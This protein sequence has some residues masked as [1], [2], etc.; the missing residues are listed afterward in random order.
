MFHYSKWIEKNLSKIVYCEYQSLI[1]EIFENCDYFALSLDTGYV[2]WLKY[3]KTINVS[4]EK[5]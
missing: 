2:L 3:G 1:C 5:I 4:T